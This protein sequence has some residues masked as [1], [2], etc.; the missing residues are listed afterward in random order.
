[1][2]PA[3]LKA[4]QEFTPVPSQSRQSPGRVT[5]ISAR[6][7]VDQYLEH[8][9]ASDF[10]DQVQQ[11]PGEGTKTLVRALLYYQETVIKPLKK[12]RSKDLMAPV[13]EELMIAV[14]EFTSIPNPPKKQQAKNVGAR[15]YIDR[16]ME[17]RQAYSFLQEMQKMPGEGNKAVVRALLHYKANIYDR[18]LAELESQSAKEVYSRTRSN[19]KGRTG[20]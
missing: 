8:K 3:L 1:M 6:L 16:F 10:L 5:S 17:H 13:P 12:L 11:N 4:R 9:L 19:K 2:D 20:K 18:L 15:L 14:I 7:Y